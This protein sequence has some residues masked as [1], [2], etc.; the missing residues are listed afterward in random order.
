MQASSP[1]L[2]SSAPAPEPLATSSSTLPVEHLSPHDIVTYF[3][4][5]HEMELH[6]AQ[7]LS[8]RTGQPV[9]ARTPLG[10]PPSLHSPLGPPPGESSN[11]MQGRLIV[12]IHD[13]LVYEDPD[14]TGIPALFPSEQNHAK[15]FLR[16]HG[17]T[18]M[19]NSWG[20]SG[21]P[22]LVVR[23]GDGSYY[24]VEFKETH[25]WEGYHEAHGRFFDILQVIAECRLVEATWG[26]AP[27]AGVVYYGDT[28]GSGERQGTVEVPYGEPQRAW[29]QRAMTLIRADRIR[30]PVPAERNCNHCEPNRDGL[31]KYAQAGFSTSHRNEPE[32]PTHRRRFY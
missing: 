8:W 27:R 24:P 10:T 23:R 25:L 2:P 14:E 18:L 6:R 20:L 21:R 17:P 32:E 29:L 12:S 4:C 26:A 9:A 28:E 19:D 5:P 7:H 31:C 22:D 11:A 13:Q 1:P 30:A 16:D 3:R 15:A